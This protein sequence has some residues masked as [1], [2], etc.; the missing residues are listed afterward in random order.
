M[1][2][3]K[4][5]VLMMVAQLNIPNPV[6]VFT[7]FWTSEHFGFKIFRLEKTDEVFLN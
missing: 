6:P 1:S 3:A 7:K 2:T 5:K 4:A